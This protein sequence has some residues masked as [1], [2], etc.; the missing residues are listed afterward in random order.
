MFERSYVKI[1]IEPRL[2][3]R[4]NAHFIL[5][6]YFIYASKIYVRVHA[7]RIPAP[8]ADPRALAWFFALGG[9]FPGV[10]TLELS[11]APG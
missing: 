4:L 9:T 1:K 2:T 8:R 5:C 10:G 3:S 7:R 6:L 11:N